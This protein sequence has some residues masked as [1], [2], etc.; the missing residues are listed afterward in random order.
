MSPRRLLLPALG[1]LAAFSLAGQL[2]SSAQSAIQPPRPI[3]PQIVRDQDDMTSAVLPNEFA[4]VGFGK[5]QPVSV[6]VAH[7]EK[8]DKTAKVTLTATSESD[9]TK[10]AVVTYTVK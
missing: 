7:D 3:D 2:S 1:F 4:A 6:L 9:K 5:S 10:S 8:A